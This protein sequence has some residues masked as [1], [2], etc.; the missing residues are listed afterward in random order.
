M[1]KGTNYSAEELNN[2]LDLVDEIFPISETQWDR[3]AEHH[4]LGYPDKGCSVDSL[5]RKF[6]ELH[7]KRISTRD[8]DCPPAVHRAKRLRRAIIDLMDGSDLNSPLREDN[9]DDEESHFKSSSNDGDELPLEDFHFDANVG[10]DDNSGE[11][12]GG[13]GARS[14][15]R[16]SGT[17]AI[18]HPASRASGTAAGSDEPIRGEREDV[19]VPAGRAQL[20][21]SE[22]SESV[23][24]AGSSR[25]RG[26][27]SSSSSV[28]H[29]TSA[30]LTPISRPRN[31]QREDSPECPGLHLGNV[32]EMMMM[33]QALDRDEQQE[34]REERCQ[35]FCLQVKMQHQ[36]MQVQQNMMA[37]IMMT[38]MGWSDSV[39]SN[40][41]IVNMLS[42]QSTHQRN[43]GEGNSRNEQNRE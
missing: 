32:V 16:A 2:F 6:K 29:R 13:R 4:M 20:P 3:V 40:G 26:R 15:S 22:A 34:E 38:M 1:P 24:V 35:E 36:Q 17:A 19:A 39:P 12:D 9:G 43:K 33:S 5:K 21:P 11:V 37:M 8:P 7:I 10:K 27:S 31:C 25:R 30:H 23:A 42:G 18:A 14:A 28:F 41:G